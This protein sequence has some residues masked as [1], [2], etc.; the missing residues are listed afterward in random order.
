MEKFVRLF[1]PVGLM[2][3]LGYTAAC[4]TSEPARQLRW[5]SAPISDF[6]SVAGKWEGL[7]KRIPQAR[8]DDWVKVVIHED[9]HYEF[10]SYRMIGVFSGRGQLNLTDGKVT[11]SSERGAV[12]CTLYTDEGQ[13][14][15]RAVGITKDGLEY[16][17][18]LEPVKQ[19]H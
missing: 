5:N 2:A 18:D 12:T 8:S 16:T 4:A 17:A 10:A 1:L 7:M 11:S 13:R 14:M 9:G 19:K 3:V 15:L 6:G